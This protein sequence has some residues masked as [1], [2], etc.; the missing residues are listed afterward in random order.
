MVMEIPL[1]IRPKDDMH[2][3]VYRIGNEGER[4][5]CVWH[6]A[7]G[8]AY[9]TPVTVNLNTARIAI[10]VAQNEGARITTWGLPVGQGDQD[11]TSQ[12]HVER[13]VWQLPDPDEEECT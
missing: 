6:N 2:L 10:A 11:L 12:V 4:Y 8:E 9:T 3:I 7:K 13:D 5:S 1:R